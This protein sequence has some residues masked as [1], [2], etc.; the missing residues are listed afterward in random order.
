[1]P[2]WKYARESM[3]NDPS[4]KTFQGHKFADVFSY[5]TLW[6]HLDRPGVY[7]DLASNDYRHISNTYFADHCLKFRGLCIEA[8]P[9]YWPNLDKKRHCAVVKTCI[10]VCFSV[11][12][13]VFAFSNRMDVLFRPG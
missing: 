10:A 1:M 9:K 6:K 5:S 2:L 8:N 7:V 13:F 11:V 12:R 3:T 4:K